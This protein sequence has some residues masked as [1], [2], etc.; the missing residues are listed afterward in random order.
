MIYN[1][2]PR[3]GFDLH[4]ETLIKLVETFPQVVA[5]KEAGDVSS[6][7]IVKRN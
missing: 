2:P 6:V 7:P 1:N 3:T 4:V 5:F